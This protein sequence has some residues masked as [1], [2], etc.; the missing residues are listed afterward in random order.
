[1]PTLL[2][3][4]FSVSE[5]RHLRLKECAS[6]MLC[7]AGRGLVPREAEERPLVHHH[8]ERAL[9]GPRDGQTPAEDCPTPPVP[10]HP[11]AGAQ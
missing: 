8:P 9:P 1:M 2:D 3:F 4:F 7:D 11:A 10:E 6:G 5:Q